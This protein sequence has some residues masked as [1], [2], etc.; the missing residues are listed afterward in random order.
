MMNRMTSRLQQAKQRA[1]RTMTRFHTPLH[2]RRAWN[3]GRV[4]VTVALG[5]LT[6]AVGWVVFAVVVE[7]IWGQMDV[8]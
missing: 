2:R 4:L 3:I 1:D 7:I 5:I 6:M 8:P